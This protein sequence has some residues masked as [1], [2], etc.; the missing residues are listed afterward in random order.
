MSYIKDIIQIH[1]KSTRTIPDIVGQA[2]TI[3]RVASLEIT[4]I[5]VPNTLYKF[6]NGNNSLILDG[7]TYTIPIGTYTFSTISAAVVTLFENAGYTNVS[8]TENDERVITISMDE[9]GSV[10]VSGGLALELGLVVGSQSLPIVGNRSR[11][12]NTYLI[13]SENRTVD[14]YVVDSDTS[15]SFQIPVGNYNIAELASTMRAQ[16]LNNVTLANWDVLFDS[17]KFKISIKSNPT[18]LTFRVLATSTAGKILGFTKNVTS[19]S[20]IAQG[21]HVTDLSG[22][23]FLYIKS[24]DVFEFMNIESIYGNIDST[25]LHS[26]PITT[27]VGE[28]INEYIT[29]RVPIKFGKVAGVILRKTFGFRLEE[30]NGRIADLGNIPWTISY[31]LN[32]Y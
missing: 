29:S 12:T 7:T 28:P 15:T 2:V 26:F 32:I 1:G 25:L 19:S 23:Q 10:I 30:K 18:S 5:G 24:L 9:T 8:V 17:N 27:N 13:E 16:M 4:Y 3:P 11:Q 21:N 14:I 20:G 31:I 22:P 6:N